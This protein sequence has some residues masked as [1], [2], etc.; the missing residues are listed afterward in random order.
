[1]RKITFSLPQELIRSA[2]IAAAQRDIS[3][4]ALVHEALEG[5]V[6]A[7][8]RSRRAAARLLRKSRTGLYEISPGFWN[9]SGLYE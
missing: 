8:S 7:R 6:T 5:A 1:M 3:V 4:N 2:K 9:R